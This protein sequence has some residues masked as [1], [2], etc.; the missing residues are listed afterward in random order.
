MVLLRHI[1]FFEIIQ[2]TFL[3]RILIINIKKHL[4]NLYHFFLLNDD[5]RAYFYFHLFYFYNFY[6]Q[7]QNFLK[8]IKISEYI[9]KN[10]IKT[11][12]KIKKF[13][14]KI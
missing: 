11:Y 7:K 1:F 6:F 2:N 5:V 3:H 13:S 14:P 9:F 4:K 10:G 12:T 8:I